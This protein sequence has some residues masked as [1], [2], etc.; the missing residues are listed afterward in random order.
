MK[1]MTISLGEDT[2]RWARVWAAQHDTSVSRM[3]G[4]LLRDRM[5]EDELY[6]KAMNS[7][8]K[9]GAAKLK[10]LGGYPSREAIHER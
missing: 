1:N 5:R 3:V 2:A 9:R 8:L 6:G 7:F 4:D 10:S